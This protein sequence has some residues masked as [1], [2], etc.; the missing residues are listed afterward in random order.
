[1]D[2]QGGHAKTK[3]KEYWG[4]SPVGIAPLRFEQAW[5][6][7]LR[8]KVALRAS[9]AGLRSLRSHFH[10]RMVPSTPADTNDL[11]F[12]FHCTLLTAPVCPK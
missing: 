3:Q 1:M 4:L 11:D 10:I 2:L 12:G 8:S 5:I 7:R 6:W 9:S